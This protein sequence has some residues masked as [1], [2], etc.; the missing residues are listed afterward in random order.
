GKNGGFG[1]IGILK[2]GGFEVPVR[3]QAT[4]LANLVTEANRV[5]RRVKEDVFFSSGGNQWAVFGSIIPSGSDL[6]INNI[7][8]GDG[9]RVWVTGG[10]TTVEDVDLYLYDSNNRLLA[11]DE[12]DD[13]RPLI[14]YRTKL[15]QRYSVRIKNV[16]SRGAS[17]VL[18]ATLSLD[19]GR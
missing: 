12:D 17:L 3:N 13:A 16:R 6:T 11:K 7:T 18:V 9:Q 2:T 8:P 1:T 10:D 4:A 14:S 19:E 5:D 15:D